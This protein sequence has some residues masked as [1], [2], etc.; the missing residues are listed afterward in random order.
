MFGNEICILAS[1]NAEI[2]YSTDAIMHFSVKLQYF[3]AN[4]FP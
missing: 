4:I 1:F 3:D 2:G